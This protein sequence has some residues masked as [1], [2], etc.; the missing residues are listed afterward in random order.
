MSAVEYKKISNDEEGM[1][2]D[3]WFKKHYPDLPHS[4]IEKIIRKGEVRLDKKRCKSKDSLQAGQ[5]VR[6]PP[7]KLIEK[8]PVKVK[9]SLAAD[10]MATF[11]AT[12]LHEDD[13]IVVF[14]KPKNLAV[15]GGSKVYV[16]VDD[17]LKSSYFKKP[18]HIVHR[19]DKDT[20]GILLAA[21]HKLAAKRLTAQFEQ[22]K[23]QKKYWA[24]VVGPLPT[25]EGEITLPLL[26]D[27][28]K[29]VVDQQGQKAM[30]R[31]SMREKLDQ[32]YWLELEPVTGRKHQ[33]RVHCAASGFPVL[34]DG[35][36][37]GAEAHPSIIPNV[38]SFEMHLHARHIAFKH[39]GTGEKVSFEAALQGQMKKTWE[40]FG[41]MA[42]SGS[43]EF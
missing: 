5:E 36:Y 32:L 34:G 21:K 16:S 30:T 39:P 31:F 18:A 37:G 9:V 26:N 15:Q 23:V 29:V 33:I 8:K 7:M 28:Q 3:K 41:L 25:Y 24:I 13:D 11:K 1:R 27:G 42:T 14:N 12:I 40:F 35:K 38:K 19:I 22:K 6:I 20:S 4:H 2:L 10:E 43:S 17:F